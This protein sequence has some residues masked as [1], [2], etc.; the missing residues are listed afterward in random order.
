MWKIPDRV[1]VRNIFHKNVIGN[2]K[3]SEILNDSGSGGGGFSELSDSDA[4]E[5]NSPL[6]NSS[7]EE[8][9]FQS[10][11]DR[12]RKRTRRAIP[13]RANTDFQFGWKEETQTV[14]KPAFSRLQGK[15]RNFHVTQ[16]SSTWDMF[17]IFFSSDMFKLIQKETKRYTRASQKLSG[18]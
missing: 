2:D 5:V 7:E 17:K 11:P 3:I 18:M 10:E 14:Q 13:K 8:E 16:D 4:Y 6:S 15:N 1:L 12:G 9:V